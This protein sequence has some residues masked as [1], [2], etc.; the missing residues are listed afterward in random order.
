[1]LSI[2]EFPDIG[3]F[4]DFSKKLNDEIKRNSR[5][6]YRMLKEMYQA[7]VQYKNKD[8]LNL[9]TK[10]LNECTP[11]ALKHHKIYIANA[12]KKYPNK[13]FNTLSDKIILTDFQRNEVDAEFNGV[14]T[15]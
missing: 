2:K 8:A 4:D 9:I 12:L 15:P 13:I 10:S 11:E 3:F 5:F 14:L 6:D 7:I 1:M